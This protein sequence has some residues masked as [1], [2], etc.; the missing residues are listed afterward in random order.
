M[1]AGVCENGRISSDL[2]GEKGGAVWVCT[3][4]L[5]PKG[6]E[7]IV[8]FALGESDCCV[9]VPNTPSTRLQTTLNCVA[10][11][12]FVPELYYFNAAVTA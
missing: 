6:G 7:Y 12:E 10:F 5:H 3:K 2:Q 11:R 1:G 8:A 9:K 4:G